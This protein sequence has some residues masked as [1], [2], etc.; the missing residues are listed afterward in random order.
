[1]L[2]VL[3][4]YWEDGALRRRPDAGPE[5]AAELALLAAFLGLDG[6]VGY[7]VRAP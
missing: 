7:P 4:V 5:L 2:R 3:A 1:M 6:V